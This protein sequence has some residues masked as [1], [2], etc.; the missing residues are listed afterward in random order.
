[1]AIIIWPWPYLRGDSFQR[2]LQPQSSVLG[3]DE[4]VH[5]C[6]WLGIGEVQSYTH[7]NVEKPLSVAGMAENATQL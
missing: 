3:F 5:A 6:G 2:S 1:M 4:G 7:H